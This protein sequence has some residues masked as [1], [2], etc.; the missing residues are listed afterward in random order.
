VD[1][2]TARMKVGVKESRDGKRE[3]KRSPKK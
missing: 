3:R 2:K 1:K